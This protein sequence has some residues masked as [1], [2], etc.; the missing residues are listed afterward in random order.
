MPWPRSI[1]VVLHDLPLGGTER[2]A[3]RLSRAWISLGV[4]VTLFVGLPEGPLAPLVPAGARL[5]AADPP[6][7]RRRGSRRRLGDAAARHFAASPVDALF[8][9]GNWHWDVVPALAALRP[10][11]VIVAQASSPLAMPRRGRL[12]QWWFERRMRRTLRAVN[13]VAAM[14]AMS[15]CDTDRILGRR[16]ARVISLPAIDDDAGPPRAPPSAPLVLAAGRL[17]RQKGFDLLIDAVAALPDVRLT[18]VG[19]GPERV[20][21]ARLIGRRGLAGR[22]TLAGFADDIR[23]WLDRCRLFVLP[24]RYEGYGAVIVEALA[25]GRPVIA[26]RTTPAADDLLGVPARGLVVP[27][28]DVPALADAIS[29]M[30]A[31]PPPDPAM[32]AAATG[33]YRLATGAAAY[34][35]LFADARA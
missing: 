2:I 11:S 7:P 25:A 31:A 9:I 18:I 12:R 27:P 20:R 21:L 35:D 14:D 3:L 6:L 8:V 34:L 33:C 19:D 13:A 26:T 22:V 29:A 4:E 28:D 16:V 24:S 23:P 5:V 10:R 17:I 30:L 15:A 1:G 32:L